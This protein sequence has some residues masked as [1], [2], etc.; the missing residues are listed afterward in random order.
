MIVRLT[1]EVKDISLK[2]F[3]TTFASLQEIAEITS[4]MVSS[5]PGVMYGPLYYRALKSAKSE[6]FEQ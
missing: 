3:W 1:P 5:F 4:L 2:L 6:E